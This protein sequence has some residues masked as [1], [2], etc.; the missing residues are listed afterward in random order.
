MDY[1]NGVFDLKMNIYWM[2]ITREDTLLG[3]I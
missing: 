3:F 2:A 1:S